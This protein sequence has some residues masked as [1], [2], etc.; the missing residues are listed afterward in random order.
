MKIVIAAI[1]FLIFTKLLLF[2]SWL[3][4][5][6]EYHWGRFKAHF[7]TYKINKILSSFWSIKFPKL[8]KKQA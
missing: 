7:E 6:K 1:W 5:L 2:W 3:W 4:Q 8:T